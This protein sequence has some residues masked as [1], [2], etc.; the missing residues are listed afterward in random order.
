MHLFDQDDKKNAEEVV[1]AEIFVYRIQE[2]LERKPQK[3]HTLIKDT[4]SEHDLKFLATKYTQRDTYQGCFMVKYFDFIGDY[5]QIEKNG[6][7]GGLNQLSF[8]SFNRKRKISTS[9]KSSAGGIKRIE[10]V[11]PPESQ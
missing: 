2:F 4:I 9:L 11:T 7:G 8:N 10:D 1:S 6:L 3:G 5:D